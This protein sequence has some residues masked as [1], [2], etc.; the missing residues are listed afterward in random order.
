MEGDNIYSVWIPQDHEVIW[1]SACTP[2]FAA[3][4]RS[5]CEGI[6]SKDSGGLGAIA[7]GQLHRESVAL[8][9]RDC[10]C[11][12]SEYEVF[13]VC[14]ERVFQVVFWLVLKPWAGVHISLPFISVFFD[15]GE[16]EDSPRALKSVWGMLA[17]G[18]PRMG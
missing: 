15:G 6:G 5:M 17:F 16:E 7:R 13:D 10:S 1:S 12:G 2:G 8:L 4:G 3:F 18:H 11:E 9:E 14:N